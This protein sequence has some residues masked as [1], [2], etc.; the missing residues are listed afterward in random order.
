[1]HT[2]STNGNGSTG[3]ATRAAETAHSVV[4][5]VAGATAPMVDRLASTAHATVDKAASAANRLEKKGGKLVEASDEFLSS[6]GSYVRGRPL[7]VL[8]VGVAAGLLISR[9]IR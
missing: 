6:A 8:G 3:I 7:V 5:R 2:N 1:M 9:L 4:D